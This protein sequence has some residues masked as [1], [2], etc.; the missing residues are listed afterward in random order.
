MENI[1][2]NI[3]DRVIIL[4]AGPIG[5]LFLQV[6]HLRGAASVS[7]FE[8]RDS[9]IKLAEQYGATHLLQELTTHEKEKF[10]V[11]IEATGSISLMDQ[12]IDLARPGGRIL[13]FGVPAAKDVM[14]LPAIQVFKKG[15]TIM[16]SFTSLRNSFQALS[17]LQ[18]GNVDVADLISHTLPLKE[19]ERGVKMI[20]EGKENVKKVMILPHR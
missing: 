13:L 10:D 9:R 6:S 2:I 14:K 7:V 16:S 15:L 11:V 4:G 8:K 1:N 12:C 3:S 5:Q 18:R 19:F 20:V 17:L